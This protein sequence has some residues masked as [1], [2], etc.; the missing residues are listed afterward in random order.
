MEVSGEKVAVNSDT[1]FQV[2]D[3]DTG[4]QVF[5]TDFSQ[6]RFPDEMKSLKTSQAV[7]NRVI[8]TK[9]I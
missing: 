6:L 8:Y 2:I 3:P 5:S 7:A 4:H 9:Y 1:G